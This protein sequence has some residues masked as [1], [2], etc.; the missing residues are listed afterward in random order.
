MLGTGHESGYLVAGQPKDGVQSA[1]GRL[2][3]KSKSKEVVL[4]TR[5]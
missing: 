5:V 1:V 2:V 3:E 4:I